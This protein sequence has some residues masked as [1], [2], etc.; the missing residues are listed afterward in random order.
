MQSNTH[1]SRRI[2]ANPRRE[3][4]IALMLALNSLGTVSYAADPPPD[5]AKRVA[6]R[7]AKNEFERAHYTYRQTVVVE[8]FDDRGSRTGEYRE[9]RDVIFSPVGDRTEVTVGKPTNNLKRLKLT[10]EDFADIRDV[11]PFLFTPDR[12]WVYETKFRGEEAVDGIDC[13]LLDVRPRQML[14]GQRYFDGTFWVD[15][16]DY[17]IIRSE[18]K[19]VPQRLS[20]NAAR[21]NLFPRFTTIRQQFGEYWF[22]IRTYGDDTLY[23]SHG[24]VRMKLTIRYSD[25]KRFGSESTITIEK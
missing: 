13:Y 2:V 8:D 18:G 15:K 9:V 23:F 4:C 14:Q 1:T 19:A 20:T 5:L 22:P 12:V 24:P 16:R 25:Y 6:E 7:E 17:S 3:F 21:E 11:Q 10:D